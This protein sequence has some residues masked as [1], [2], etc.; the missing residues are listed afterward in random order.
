M[1]AYRK[2]VQPL[3][4]ISREIV[5]LK[6]LGGFTHREIAESL[7]LPAGTVRWKYHAAVHS[8]RL[9]WGDL[10]AF[11]LF[12]ALS[13]ASVPSLLREP[14]A[15]AEGSAAP[16]AP[17]SLEI[18]PFFCFALPALLF[19]ILFLPLLR[20]VRKRRKSAVDAADKPIK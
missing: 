11:F 3:D 15:G 14:A 5:T 12:L 19:L 18:F 9:L 4:G 10:A 13:L 17:A 6:I 20:T 1:E 8:L 16:L 7:H 2:L